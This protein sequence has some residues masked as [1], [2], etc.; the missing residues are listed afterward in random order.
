[1]SK[2]FPVQEPTWSLESIFEGGVKSESFDRE[3][4]ELPGVLQG[5][6]G[7]VTEL[8]EPGGPEV[9][10]AELEQWRSFLADHFVAIERVG[11]CGAFARGQGAAFADDPE[12]ARMISRLEE[13]F[14]LMSRLRVACQLRFRGLSE[15]RFQLFL[16]A[17][18]FEEW[19][20]WLKDLRRDGDQSLAP[21]QE[22]LVVD[23]AR[24]GFHAWWN[25]YTRV[26]GELKV[27]VDGEEYSVGQTAPLLE[28]PDRKRR[29]AAHR[30]L[31]KAWGSIA[32]VCAAALNSKVGFEQTLYRRRGQDCL[33]RALQLNRVEEESVETMMGV[34][35]EFRP[36]LQ[37]YLEAKARALGLEQLSWWDLR[38]PIGSTEEEKVSYSEAQQFIVDQVEEFS[39]KMAEFFRFA[40]ASR[41]VEVEDRPGKAQGGFCSGFPK[42]REFRIFMTFGGTT[43]GVTTLAHELGHGYHFWVMRKMSRAQT[44]VPMTLAETASTLAEAL[45]E[46]AALR[47]ATEARE[48][49]LLDDRLGRALAFLGNLPGRYE[50]EKELHRVRGEGVLDKELLTELTAKIFDEA[51]GGVVSDVDGLY[52]ASKL[53]F[54]LTRYPFYNFPYTF[55]YLF[56]RAVMARAEEEGP[57]FV[58]RIDELLMHSGRLSCEEVA[59]RFLD[60]DLGDPSF[61]RAAAGGLEADVER[62]EALVEKTESQ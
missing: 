6:L 22:A 47:E 5:L 11:D 13:T 32:T 42:S 30:G 51:Y 25:L 26:S 28:S 17:P 53:H 50:L 43:S 8:P 16:D 52:W 40:L 55:G 62:Y 1:M 27:D 54:Y 21:E 48:L 3:V 37:R 20:R 33:T 31:Q 19:G 7:R 15:E 2:P 58:D 49:G 41:W 34:A 12:A 38:A 23:L 36:L 60:A 35:R 59:E 61:W 4:Q 44:Q 14:T 57:G 9:G 24:D 45:V 10:A 56:S 29:E 46:Q 18:G 39:P